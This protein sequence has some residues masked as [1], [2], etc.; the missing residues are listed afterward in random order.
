MPRRSLRFLSALALVSIAAAACGGGS[1]DDG[2]DGSAGTGGGSSG[3]AGSAAGTAGTG[4]STAGAGGTTAGTGGATAGTGGTTAGS[5]GAG[6]AG[7]T[8]GKGGTGGTTGGSGGSTGGTAG[9]AGGKAGGAG[10]PP[11]VEPTPVACNT[12]LAPAAT[13]VCDVKKGTTKAIVVR[14]R[15][16]G[17]DKIYEGGE[18][19]VDDKGLIACVG[20]DCSTTAGYAA[21]SVVTCADG[22]VTPALLNPHDHLTYA[23]NAP[24]PS[25]VRY[26][27]RNEWRKGQNGK[28]QISPPANSGANTDDTVWWGE[29][30]HLLSGATSVSG[31]PGT[32]KG[33]V[34]RNLDRTDPFQEGLGQPAVDTSIF[35]LGDSDGKVHTTC[36]FAVADKQATIDKDDAYDPHVSEGVSDGSH[37]EFVCMSGATGSQLNALK[38]Q[39]AYIHGVAITAADA[40]SMGNSGTGLIWSPRSNISLYGFTAPVVMAARAGVQIALGTDWSASGGMNM[41]RELTCAAQFNTTHLGGYFTDY[42]LYRMVTEDAAA[43][44]ASDDKL[45]ALKVGLWG[46]ITVFAGKGKAPFAAVVGADVPDVNLVLRGGNVLYGEGELVDALSSDGGAG[47]ELLTNCLSTNK[48]CAKRETGK[49]IAEMQAAIGGTPYPLYFCGTPTDEPTCVP[50]RPNEFTGV[51][52]ADDTDGDGLKNDV[53]LC[54]TVFSAPRPM[55]KG[56]QLDTDGDGVGDHCDPCPQKANSN[57]CAPVAGD[58]DGDTVPDASDNCPSVANLDQKDGDGDGKGDACDACPTVAN[59]G[60]MACPVQTLTVPQV[61]ALADN[62]EVAVSG[63]CVTA[64]RGSGTSFTTW[65][66]D[67]TLAENAGIVVFAN[68]A[69]GVAIGDKIDVTG[70]TSTFNGLKELTKPVITKTGSGCTVTPLVVDPAS[71]ATN[72]ANMGKYMSMLIQVDNVTVTGTATGN[73][74]VVTGDLHIDDFIFKLVPTD[75]PVGTVFT[76]VRGPLDYFTDHS[77]IDPRDAADLIKLAER[78][79]PRRPASPQGFAGLSASAPG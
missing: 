78:R 20:C 28:P 61:R 39:S 58:S 11:V 79:F 53:D 40:A 59:P 54:P 5:G 74:L 45:G 51:P 27:Y 4:G 37:L 68:A 42:Q 18:V 16:V 77:K 63:L 60:A 26:D 21:A 56:K 17:Q 32:A 75:Y 71:V 25:A 44:M 6:A 8:A 47:C 50:S 52:S 41:L 66:Q 30:R 70:T 2:L 15:V 23:H 29:I 69:P 43:L 7:G 49:T 48:V 9:S 22:V 67:P 14:G 3:S 12:N 24:K 33:G 46:D 65:V 38:P 19:V 76:S 13:G 72:G 31:S 62:V 64:L 73:E 1:D 55:D 10:A 35:P 57:D 34:L 36:D